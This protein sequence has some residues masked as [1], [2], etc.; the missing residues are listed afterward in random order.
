MG[1][2]VIAEAVRAWGGVDVPWSTTRAGV[3]ARGSSHAI[4]IG[5]RWHKLVDINL[6]ATIEATQAAI[7]A[8]CADDTAGGSIVTVASEAAFGQIRQ[9]VYGATKAAQVAL[10]RTVAREHGRPARDPLQCRLPRSDGSP[11]DRRPSGEEPVG[12][13]H[14]RRLQRQPDQLPSQRRPV[15][16]ADTR[17]RHRQRDPAAQFGYRCP[18]GDWTADLGQRRLYDAMTAD[19]HRAGNMGSG[20]DTRDRLLRCTATILASKGYR[21]D[22]SARHRSPG[23][24]VRSPAIYYHFASRDELVPRRSAWASSGSGSRCRRPSTQ[25]ADRG[26]S[27]WPPR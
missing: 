6:F 11:T 18:A 12:G 1:E 21:A 20:L 13:R 25:P 3:S 19:S 27:N 26:T 14:R 22:P 17:R 2:H 4:T 5:T 24:G 7:A 8:I 23:P 9:G 15:A 16:T 10:A